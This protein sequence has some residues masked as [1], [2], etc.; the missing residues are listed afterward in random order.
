[1]AQRVSTA[2]RLHRYDASVLDSASLDQL[3][4]V[5]LTELGLLAGDRKGERFFEERIRRLRF[6]HSV[7]VEIRRRGVQL[8]LLPD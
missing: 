6:A 1:M 7:A 2:Q 3:W 4:Q 8:S 5:L